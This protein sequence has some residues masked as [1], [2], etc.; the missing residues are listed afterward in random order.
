MAGTVSGRTVLVVDDEESVRDMMASF[1]QTKG[2]GARSAAGGGEA[3]ALITQERPDLVILDL[4]MPRMDGIEALAE[5]KRSD[6]HIP[7]VVMTGYGTVDSAV[8]AMKLGAQDYITKPFK[9]AEL[10][11][12]VE[13]ALAAP[14]SRCPVPQEELEEAMGHGAQVT[15]VYELVD[16]VASTNLTV[17][18]YGETGAGKSLVAAAVHRAS[19]RAGKHLVRVDCGAIPDTLI[20]SE[21]FGHER[22]AFTGA[23]HRKP[24]Y[25]ELADG[26]T[27]FLDEI[28][29]LSEAMMRKLLCALEDRQ[30]YRVG[31]KEPIDVDIRVVA[32]SNQDLGRLVEE[33]R[34]RR[35]LFHRLNEFVIAIPP[36]RKR[37]GDIPFLVER[38]VRLANQDL[39]KHVR[40]ASPEAMKSLESNDWPGNARELRNVVRR[41]VLL[42][43]GMIE[44]ENLRVASTACAQPV[45]AREASPALDHIF[46]GEWSLRDI[47]RACIGQLEQ[48]VIGAVLEHTH[49][50][51]SKAAR[52]LSVDYKTLYYKAKRLGL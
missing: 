29:N 46:R 38:F 8:A 36:L 32:A 3:L 19:H 26:G 6:P 12:A 23:V 43:D 52:L 35:D 44:V 4:R 18:I 51:K 40:G 17:I 34:F 1:F 2:Y 22:G 14:E 5:I 47:T 41:A 25:F 20:E 24:G 11:R 15:K 50:N 37:R 42:A 7:V 39:G 27:L 16:Q 49:G 33:G 28:A 10:L 30:I 21:L 9:P 48:N 31:G 13:R 45:A